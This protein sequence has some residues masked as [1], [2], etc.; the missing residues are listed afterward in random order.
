MPD[1]IIQGSVSELLRK[2][3]GSELAIHFLVS[4]NERHWNFGCVLESEA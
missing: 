1:H 3:S 2:G 4:V